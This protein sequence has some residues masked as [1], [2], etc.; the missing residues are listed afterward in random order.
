MHQRL[1]K[2]VLAALQQHGHREPVLSCEHCR[3]VLL[4][5]TQQRV[6]IPALKRLAVQKGVRLDDVMVALSKV[7][8]LK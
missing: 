2:T 6:V 4:T 8:I 7:S 5:Y 3:A 1:P